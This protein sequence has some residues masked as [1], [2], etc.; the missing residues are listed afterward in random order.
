VSENDIDEDD[1]PTVQS[2]VD[3]N[4]HDRAQFTLQAL[5][6]D[7]EGEFVLVQI[8]ND[9]FV[10]VNEKGKLTV[11]RQ[12]ALHA[13]LPAAA[14]RL[15]CHRRRLG[16]RQ[17][18]RVDDRDNP[19][20]LARRHAVRAARGGGQ[21][22]QAAGSGEAAPSAALPWSVSLRSAKSSCSAAPADSCVGARLAT[23]SPRRDRCITERARAPN[24]ARGFLRLELLHRQLSGLFSNNRDAVEP[25]TLSLIPFGHR[26]RPAGPVRGDVSRRDAHT[27]HV[28]L[29]YI[30]KVVLLLATK[31]AETLDVNLRLHVQFSSC[32]GATNF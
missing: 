24:R 2:G 29:A 22:R 23:D 16:P 28:V 9:D 6:S 3:S 4:K 5:M 20:R 27:Y 10:T 13:H 31:S 30:E 26:S 15:R 8:Q 7:D 32:R 25:T 19:L 17:H 14:H 21:R 11:R 1:L 18:G 12:A